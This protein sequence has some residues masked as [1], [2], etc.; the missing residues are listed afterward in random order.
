MKRILQ[1]YVSKDLSM[2]AYNKAM[3]TYNKT[4]SEKPKNELSS[5]TAKGSMLRNMHFA[6]FYQLIGMYDK[7]IKKLPISLA[8]M[9]PKKILGLWLTRKEL[10]DKLQI[11]PKTVYNI[12]QRLAEADF[13]QLI[14]HGSTKPIEIKISPELL[15]IYDKTDPDYSPKSK[16][17]KSSVLSSLNKKWKKLPNI[18]YS[19]N[20]FN[21][22]I[23][24]TEKGVFLISTRKDLPELKILPG[25]LS[26]QENEKNIE[27]VNYTKTFTE[28]KEADKAGI[29]DD[30]SERLDFASL[31]EKRKKVPQKKEKSLEDRR[32]EVKQAY[33]RI[34]FAYMKSKLFADKVFAKPYEQQ[35]INY[36]AEHYYSKTY[37]IEAISKRWDNNLKPRIDIAKEWIDNFKGPNDAKFDTKYF[38]PLSF[39]QIDKTQKSQFSFTRTNKFL[40][41]SK[42]FEQ[43]NNYNRKLDKELR[44]KFNKICRSVE[45][46]H[47]DYFTALEKIK[48]LTKDSNEYLKQFNARFAGSYTN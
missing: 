9:Y 31:E 6:V 32:M 15:I 11:N 38:Y 17:L 4:I 22:N 13:L 1:P 18:N 12:L 10:A 39:L 19:T 5:Q 7:R 41:N 46:N 48:S 44:H 27:K 16:F 37:T 23:T 29:M 33:A 30:F 26:E 42:K 40:K 20:T 34:M 3:R 2:Q 24:I 47:V 28:T 8:A 45:T 14:W 21:N 25:S 43:L 36:I 35:V